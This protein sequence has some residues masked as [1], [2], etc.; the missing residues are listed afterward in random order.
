MTFENNILLISGPKVPCQT[1]PEVVSTEALIFIFLYR[2]C[3]REWGD[4]SSVQFQSGPHF[5]HVFPKHKSLIQVRSS[6]L[7]RL[8]LCFKAR[9]SLHQSWYVR[10]LQHSYGA[11]RYAEPTVLISGNTRRKWNDIS[12]FKPGQRIGTRPYAPTGAKRN[13]DDERIGMA[14]AAFHSFSEFPNLGKEPVCQKWNGEFRS[15]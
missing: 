11:F 9:W 13:D 14:L 1:K 3:H 12:R 10:S 2:L 15:N 4:K 5:T 8:K 7:K 6:H